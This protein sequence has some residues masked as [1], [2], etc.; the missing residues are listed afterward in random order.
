[1]R[2][3]T[4]GLSAADRIVVNGV[5]RVRPGQTVR[6]HMVPM[7]DDPAGGGEGSASADAGQAGADPSTNS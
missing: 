1:L 4:A 7:T 5:Q 6:A 2:V 3:I